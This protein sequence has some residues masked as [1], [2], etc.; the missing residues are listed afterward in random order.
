MSYIVDSLLPDEKIVH[1]AHYHWIVFINE[2]IMATTS[3]VA[4]MSVDSRNEAI[5]S[6]ISIGVM[7]ISMLM[8]MITYAKVAT[9]EFVVTNRRVIIKTGWISCLFA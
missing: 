9:A 7:G 3:F 1:S 8:G 2:I 5:V 4:F 6:V